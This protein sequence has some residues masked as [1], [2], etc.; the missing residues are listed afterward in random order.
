MRKR[1]DPATELGGRLSQSE[2]RIV[3]EEIRKK[4]KPKTTVA[5]ALD[6]WGKGAKKAESLTLM[7]TAADTASTL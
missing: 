4:C 2:V 3:F 5:S 1:R 6:A 7:D